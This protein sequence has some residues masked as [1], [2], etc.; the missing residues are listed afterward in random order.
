MHVKQIVIRQPSEL[1]GKLP[2]LHDRDPA[3]LLA[4]GSVEHLN[5]AGF[6]ETLHDSFP[7]AFLLGCSTAGEITPEGVSDGS[8]TI[9]AQ[10]GRAHV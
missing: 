8:C 6:S 2:F 9:T 4:F 3:L 1:A 7:R 10:I 5:A